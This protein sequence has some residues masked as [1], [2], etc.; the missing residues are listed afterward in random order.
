MIEIDPAV[1][2]SIK[3]LA[4]CPEDTI[5]SPQGAGTY[6]PA[7]R[8]FYT[9][10]LYTNNTAP[11][12]VYYQ[13]ITTNLDN[14]K[15]EILRINEGGKP[16]PMPAYDR[17]SCARRPRSVRSLAPPSNQPPSYARRAPAV[18]SIDVV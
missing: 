6:D 16:G 12:T 15:Y 7:T 1:D 18:W 14:P 8:N 3:V 17:E 2:D 5:S 11:M 4:S 13:L 9:V 10:M